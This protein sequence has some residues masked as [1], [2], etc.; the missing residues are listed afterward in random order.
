MCDA[1]GVN[2]L[3]G[4]KGEDMTADA[5]CCASWQFHSNFKYKT[6]QKGKRWSQT[7]SARKKERKR[8][9]QG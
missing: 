1:S 7:V 2:L 9:K 3:R 6:S 5:W 4:V 8:R